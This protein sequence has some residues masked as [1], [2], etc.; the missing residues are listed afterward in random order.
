MKKPESV[1]L[2]EAK[3]KGIAL[4][5][6]RDIAAQLLANP[7]IGVCAAVAVIEIGQRIKFDGTHQ[8]ITE[9]TGN[10]IET[11]AITATGLK[12]VGDAA[13]ALIPIGKFIKGLGSSGG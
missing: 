8:L 4:E 9:T 12:A 5:C 1:L 3:N 2:Q 10:A 13:G 11:I 6:A 7:I